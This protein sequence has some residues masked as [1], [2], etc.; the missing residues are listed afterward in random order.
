MLELLFKDP[1]VWG[2][3]L[4]LPLLLASVVIIYICS[5]TTQT[6][7]YKP[8]VS[9]LIKNAMITLK[10][11]FLDPLVFTTSTIKSAHHWFQ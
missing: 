4:V 6:T 11:R 5:C 1:V 7:T 10:W 9:L 3:L 8:F 2:S